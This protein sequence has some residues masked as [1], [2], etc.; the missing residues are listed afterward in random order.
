M[1]KTS[2]YAVATSA[3]VREGALGG[4]AEEKVD[5]LSPVWRWRRRRLKTRAKRLQ[6]P[7]SPNHLTNQ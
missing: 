4:L 5:E 1:A 7:T 6:H 2:S 3:F